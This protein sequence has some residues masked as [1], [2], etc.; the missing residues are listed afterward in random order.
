MDAQICSK[1]A[2]I[3]V[4]MINTEFMVKVTSEEQGEEW[5]WE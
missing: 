4:G 1:R 5:G 3:Y 2:K